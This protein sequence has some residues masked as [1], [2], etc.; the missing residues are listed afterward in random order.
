MLISVSCLKTDP[1]KMSGCVHTA[2]SVIALEIWLQLHWKVQDILSPME[3]EVWVS[4]GTW[5]L[6]SESIF[7]SDLR[8]SFTLSV[9]L[10]PPHPPYPHRDSTVL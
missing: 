5:V 4:Q 2:V 7:L 6:W 10:P 8:M 9:L 1:D 3:T